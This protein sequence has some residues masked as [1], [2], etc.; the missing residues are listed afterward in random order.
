M[1]AK[2][3]ATAGA[4]LDY[5]L[6]GLVAS[7]N[8]TGDLNVWL[9]TGLTASTNQLTGEST[10]LGPALFQSVGSAGTN[11]ATATAD[12]GTGQKATSE[13]VLGNGSTEWHNS[14]GST[15]TVSHIAIY[16]TT[17]ATLPAVGNLVYA[18]TLSGGDQD[19][20]ADAVATIDAGDLVITEH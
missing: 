5:I 11:W 7:G 16:N 4:T 6:D 13:K 12:S 14:T 15:I 2:S 17:G 18:G 8:A 10:E 9:G 3:E 19:I 20:G 1:G